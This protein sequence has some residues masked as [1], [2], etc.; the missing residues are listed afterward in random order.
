MVISEHS[1]SQ[2]SGDGEEAEGRAAFPAKGLSFPQRGKTGS[3]GKAVGQ[4]APGAFLME[5]SVRF[6]FFFFKFLF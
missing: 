1:S 2:G 5:F 3:K 4:E 6:F